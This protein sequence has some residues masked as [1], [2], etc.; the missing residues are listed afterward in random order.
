MSKETKRHRARYL[1][2]GVVIAVLLGGLGYGFGTGFFSTSQTGSFTD[3]SSPPQA[4]AQT[5]IITPV[6]TL[7]LKYNITVKES[8]IEY[9]GWPVTLEELRQLLF[10][11]YTGSEVYDL[12]DDHALKLQYDAVKSLLDDTGMP[13]VEK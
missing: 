5:D 4:A 13:Y 9:Q 1:A 3:T 6:P 7:D 12:C 2:A 10:D 8:G 11:S